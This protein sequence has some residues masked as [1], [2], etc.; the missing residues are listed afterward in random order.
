MTRSQAIKAYYLWLH[1]GSWPSVRACTMH[2]H[3]LYPYRHG[4]PRNDRPEDEGRQEDERTGADYR[5]D[6]PLTRKRAIRATC[7]GCRETLT[8]VAECK[9]TDCPLHDWRMGRKPATKTG[10]LRN[11]AGEEA[12]ERYRK[13]KLENKGEINGENGNE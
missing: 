5:F 8:A 10:G 7:L 9:S 13:A 4:A 6:K 12:L 1:C 3:P 2:G 11:R